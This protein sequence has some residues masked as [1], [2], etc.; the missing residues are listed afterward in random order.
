M[1]K[2]RVLVI[3]LLLI[4]VFPIKAIAAPGNETGINQKDVI[5]FIMT[6]RFN[7]GDLKNNYNS[8]KADLK[9]WHGGDL[10]GVIDKLDYI[11]DLG[12]TTIWLTPVQAQDAGGYHGYWA[13]DFK[14]VDKHFGDMEKLKEL[15]NKA[16]AKKMKVI[17]DLVV[18]HTGVLHPWV[19]D[20]AYSKWFHE[21]GSIS[22]WNNPKEVENLRLAGLPDLAQENPD[23]RK[24]L[25]DMA[26]GWIRETGIDGFRLDTVRHVPKEF[27]VE[28]TSEIK[29][30]FPN[31]YFIGEVW[32][33]NP[34]TVG[35]YQKTGIS[36]LVD[37]PMYYAITDIFAAS[38]KADEFIT[39]AAGAAQYSDR[40]LM[41]T[42]I[43]NH[44]VGRFASVAG[45]Y[46]E[47]KLKQ[48]LAF[49]MTYTGIPVIYYGTEIAMEGGEDPSNR[50][51]M[52]FTKVSDIKPW[53][54]ELIK[55]RKE[56]LALTDGDFKILKAKDYDL[57]FI[58]RYD[59][60]QIISV[61]NI[62]GKDSVMTINIESNLSAPGNTLINLLDEKEKIKLNK[63]GTA[64]INMKSKDVKIFKVVTGPDNVIWL[65]VLLVLGGGIGFGAAFLIV[66]RVTKAR[67]KK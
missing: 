2:L 25:I 30:E 4:A 5:Y 59:S 9:Y 49:E 7:D 47:E 27:W 55:I 10:Q 65:Y 36:G 12:A 23:T 41:G 28:F 33:G 16:H 61:F 58:R 51:D 64:T 43:D 57:A 13:V 37:F 6:D 48:A 40:K 20:P 60:N 22:D 35:S 21:G 42:F 19:N 34:Q 53:T 31:F 39:A 63:D 1:K 18:N 46:K 24:Y 14:A 11:K 45:M 54:Q 15:V 52:D 56:N 8:N 3:I 50:K 62:A 17:L 32:D 44:D 66:S 38:K 29:K 67:P 26:K